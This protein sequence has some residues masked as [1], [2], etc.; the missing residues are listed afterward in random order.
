MTE[1]SALPQQPL[2]WWQQLSLAQLWAILYLDAVS[3]SMAHCFLVTT[4]G[5]VKLSSLQSSFYIIWD[6]STLPSLLGL[7][8]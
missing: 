2:Q 4:M 5:G 7:D 1:A 6:I 8:S 3:S